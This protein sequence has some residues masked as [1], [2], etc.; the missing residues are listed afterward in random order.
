VPNGKSF[1]SA[2]GVESVLDDAGDAA[3]TAVVDEAA[4]VVF[5]LGLC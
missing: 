3:A 4:G 2:T 1:G 5:V